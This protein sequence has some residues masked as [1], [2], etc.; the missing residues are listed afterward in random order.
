MRRE[1][2][3]HGEWAGQ[4]QAPRELHSRADLQTVRR[5]L[6]LDGLELLA[7]GRDELLGL[8]AQLVSLQRCSSLVLLARRPSFLPHA[9]LLRLDA[10]GP[11]PAVLAVP[12]RAT[13][14]RLAALELQLLNTQKQPLLV[15]LPRLLELQVRFGVPGDAVPALADA[16]QHVQ[17]VGQHLLRVSELTHLD[18]AVRIPREGLL[19]RAPQ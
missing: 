12:S 13:V 19:A 9:F 16:V 11:H 10:A 15:T 4:Q 2:A 1:D 3:A 17:L 18:D 5:D 8:S 6:A 14:E 7:M